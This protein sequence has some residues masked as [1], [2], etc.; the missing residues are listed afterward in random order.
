MLSYSEVQ[1]DLLAEH[2]MGFYIVGYKHDHNLSLREFLYLFCTQLKSTP[3]KTVSAKVSSYI[4]TGKYGF[5]TISDIF[6][7]TRHYYPLVSLKEVRETLIELAKKNRIGV[8]NCSTIEDTVYFQYRGVYG[9]KYTECE[10]PC[11]YGWG[12]TDKIED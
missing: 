5:R 4:N 12:I 8:H 2:P 7:I 10:K 6:L 3:N 11:K 9:F 1:S